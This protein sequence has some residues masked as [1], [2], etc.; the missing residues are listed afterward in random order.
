MAKRSSLALAPK[1]PTYDV[2]HIFLEVSQDRAEELAD[3]L[4]VLA[5]GDDRILVIA[6]EIVLS[7]M[8]TDRMEE[9]TARADA[10]EWFV[11]RLFH[12]SRAYWSALEDWKRC[13]ADRTVRNHYFDDL[14]EREYTRRGG[15][16]Q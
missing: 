7:V 5:D 1:W 2:D 3:D 9:I 11:A 16:K 12:N 14:S 13:L 6:A 8:A 4:M 15:I 10:A